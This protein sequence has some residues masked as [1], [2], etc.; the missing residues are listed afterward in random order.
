MIKRVIALAWAVEPLT[1]SVCLP[2]QATLE[3]VPLP[4]ELG[5]LA[6]L[7]LPHAE[8]I[9]APMTRTLSATPDRLSF[10]SIP[11][12]DSLPSAIQTQMGLGQVDRT[13]ATGYIAAT[14]WQTPSAA[15]AMAL[16]AT[17][18][19]DL[20]ESGMGMYPLSDKPF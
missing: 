14:L 16:M 20:K 5:A 3:A 1:L 9:I 11:S 13:L 12:F 15:Q 17:D 10:N 18:N 8:S 19:L 2:P 6:F 7:S 4:D